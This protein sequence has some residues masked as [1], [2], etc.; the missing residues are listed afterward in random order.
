MHVC[1]AT[2]HGTAIPPMAEP[3]GIL[4]RLRE[5]WLGHEMEWECRGLSPLQE[6]DLL[7][8]APPGSG[9][10]D[11]ATKIIALYITYRLLI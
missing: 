3:V 1:Q 11:M 8:F 10:V 6:G 5:N 2:E 4:T 7:R 9:Q